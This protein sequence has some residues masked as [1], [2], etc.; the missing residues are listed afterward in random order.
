VQSHISTGCLSI[1]RRRCVSRRGVHGVITIVDCD[2][3]AHGKLKLDLRLVRKSIFE[4]ML[5][6]A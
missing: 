6:G 2:S 3:S 4:R 5:A 1:Q